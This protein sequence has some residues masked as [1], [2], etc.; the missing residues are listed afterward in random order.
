MMFV[1]NDINLTVQ[2]TKQTF[3]LSKPYLQ[4]VVRS[5]NKSSYPALCPSCA[6]FVCCKV[7]VYADNADAIIY[8]SVIEAVNVDK[9]IGLQDMLLSVFY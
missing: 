7:C 1:K 9:I 6:R 5:K 2:Q 8:A 3:E 4:I